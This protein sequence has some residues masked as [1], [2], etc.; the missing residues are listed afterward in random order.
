[1]S[2][3]YM[4]NKRFMTNATNSIFMEQICKYIEE[5]ED[6]APSEI[7]EFD[8]L[9]H[10]FNFEVLFKSL[11]PDKEKRNVGKIKSFFQYFESYHKN[12]FNDQEVIDQIK[13]PNDLNK[14]KKLTYHFHD[15]CYYIAKPYY[16][17]EINEEFLNKEKYNQECGKFMNYRNLKKWFETIYQDINEGRLGSDIKKANCSDFEKEKLKMQELWFWVENWLGNPLFAQGVTIN[18]LKKHIHLRVSKNNN[19]GITSINALPILSI[20]DEIKKLVECFLLIEKNS[21]GVKQ[22]IKDIQK[23]LKFLFVEYY[24][25]KFSPDIKS[26]DYLLKQLRFFPCNNCS[27]DQYKKYIDEDFI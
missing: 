27:Q 3:L 13:S 24:R 12:R 14:K 23:D 9:F 25:L 2:N 22:K 1:M 6:I 18:D 26:F 4:S 10:L 16:T 19:S 7:S 17:V 11:F 5:I 15:D 21:E 20:Y 8:D